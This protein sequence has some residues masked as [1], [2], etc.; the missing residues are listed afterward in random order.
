M[1]KILNIVMFIILDVMLF[2]ALLFSA[3]QVVV[4]NDAY[5]KWHYEQHGIEEST[6]M[7]ITNFMDV[8]H[9]MMS[10]LIDQRDSLD[11]TATINGQVEEVFGEREKSHMDDVKHLF[12][13]GKIL[14]DISAI[15]LL[16]IILYL[17]RTK[18][19]FLS[20]W[21]KQFRHFFISSFLVI[22]VFG[23]I[24]STDFNKYFTKFHELFFT[25]DLW[26]LDPETDILVNMVPEIFFFQTVLLIL[27]VF[28]IC[29]TAVILIGNWASKR[30]EN[31]TIQAK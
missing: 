6:M 22:G 3:V 4:Y 5:F 13:Q 18:N 26:L 1:N 28:I 27:L 10:Y 19:Q 9:K 29:I 11:M 24:I 25:N 23:G 12:L 16:I 2:V 31:R 20:K 7:D 30:L 21:L 15:I 17:V 14:R 8:T